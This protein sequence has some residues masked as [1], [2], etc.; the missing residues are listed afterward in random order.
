MAAGQR[1][2]AVEDVK[3][4]ELA[5]ADYMS[6]MK[7]KD[8][9]EKHGVS[10][11]TVKSWK[12]RYAWD[13]GGAHKK[14]KGC[15]QKSSGSGDKDGH[16]A[17]EIEY[18][19]KNSSLT[20][21][22]RLFCILYIR[23]FNATKAYQK[24]YGCSYEAAAANGHRL[25]KNDKV[26]EEIAR[27]KQN[28][29]NRELLAEEDIVQF[30]IDILFSDI[31]D[32]IDVKH[33]MINLASPLVDGRLIK[34]VSFGKTDSIELPDK[35]AALKWLSD[36]MDLATEKQ[37]AE[38]GLLKARAE[39]DGIGEIETESDGFLEALEASAERDWENE[40]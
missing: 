25:L 19:M 8:I 12:K 26:K 17:E 5:E 14:E 9:A 22:Q 18:V 2:G 13:R 38:I 3:N 28:R 29:L 27:L 39:R 34:K 37:R 23:C 7:Y 32:Y 36:H 21:K 6:G 16:G 20:D 11:N 40:E 31:T 33:N 35:I 1:G 24:A 10:I 4:H 30:Y 15:T